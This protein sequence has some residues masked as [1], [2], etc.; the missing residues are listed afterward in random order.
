M[1]ELVPHLLRSSDHHFT[2]FV[3]NKNEEWLSV[4]SENVNIVE[5][6][7]PHYSLAEQIRLPSIIKKSGI[8]LL[9]SP[10]FNVPL[11][12]P[13]PFVVTIHDLILH[14]YPNQA[15][16]LK[17]K[18]YRFLM[19]RSVTRAQKIIAVSAFTAGELNDVYGVSV[20][21]KVTVVH[22]GISPHFTPRSDDEQRAVRQKFDLQR[23][24]FLYVG[25]AKEHK[26][27]KLLLDAFAQAN[28]ADADLVLVSSGK[29]AERLKM[30]SNTKRLE[31]VKDDD[32]PALYSA[33][34]A[35]VTASLYEGYG[36]PVLEAA[37]CGCPVIATN[38][39]AITEVA[40]EGS[41]LLEPTVDAFSEGFQN[42][43]QAG[44]SDAR[45]W[46]EVA[47]ETL[48]ALENM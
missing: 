38:G 41:L 35:F 5:A 25:N 24:F 48:A 36:L 15:S 23:D 13:I 8:D 39:S 37:A 10:H 27:V 11:R 2:L 34:R 14:R 26:N 30:E 12:C 29:E 20:G 19:K 44:A 33:A 28:I 46:E 6:D 21:S 18:A 40:P 42:P 9:F 47:R 31:G 43:P 17:Q 22:E 4:L 32:L 7:I 1:K 3:R 16:F 45:S